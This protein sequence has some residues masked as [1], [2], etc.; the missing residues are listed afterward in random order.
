MK[1]YGIVFTLSLALISIEMIWTRILSAEFFYTFAFLVLSLAIL[2]L[3]T[4]ALTIRL[5]SGLNREKRIPLYT[6]FCFL[7]AI[8]GPIL[9]FR[10]GLDFSQLF[11]S[12]MIGLKLAGAS[13]LLSAPFFFG[14]M[15]LAIIF[16]SE[17]T[18][19]NKLYMADLFGAGTGVFTA[20]LLMNAFGT[21]MATWLITLLLLFVLFL[22]GRLPYKALAILGAAAILFTSGSAE[23]LLEK[24]REER[25]SVIYKHWDA[26]SKIKVYQYPGD[27]ARGINIDNIANTPVYKFDGNWDKPDSLLYEFGIPVD[28]LIKQFDSCTFLSLGSGG[29]ADVMQALQ[30]GANEVHAVEVNS[31]INRMMLQGHPQGYLAWGSDSAETIVTLDDYSG[32]VYHDPRV[33][34]ITEDARI[35]ARQNPAT[36]DVIYSLSSNTWSALASG[37][38]ALAENYLFTTEAFQ[39]Y[40][41]ALS[42]QGF[43]M[44]EHQFYVPR[45]V[46]EVMDA[47]EAEGLEKLHDHFAVYN[48]PQLR[49]KAILLSKRPLTDSLRYHA[50][51]DL[52]PENHDYIH[53]L[54]PAVDSLKHNDVYQ[55]VENSWQTHAD[56]VAFDISPNTDNRPFAAQMGLWKNLQKEKLEKI[57]PYE[58]FGFPLTKLLILIILGVVT[59]LI[60]PVNL[61]PFGIS[62]EKLRAPA[63]LYFFL[64]GAAFMMVE[65]ILIQKYTLFIGPSVYS[66]A[67]ILFTLLIAAGFGS[68]FSDRVENRIAFAGILICLIVDISLMRTVTQSLTGLTLPFRIG[69]S[70][71]FIAPLGFFMGMPFPKA[72]SRVGELVDWGFAVNGAASVIGSTA[73]MLVVITHGLN[74]GLLL[75]TALYGLAF[76]LFSGRSKWE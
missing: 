17:H 21:P 71:L 66:I 49:R 35:Y 58:F 47:L 43:M 60:L 40:W 72:V 15:V 53:L 76:L 16:R 67:A 31:H 57:L 10:L 70:M 6:L 5:F 62:K 11:H 19:M 36:F 42:D 45:L 55:I 56:S 41:N 8:L 24:Q 64:I 68:R 65:V 59:L 14:G 39:D 2:G 51:I 9:I 13:L 61:I 46:S 50:I 37:A 69:L 7:S 4:G 12:W 32:R 3:G 75:A 27:Q 30:F 18:R 63:W 44:M 74:V 1:K 28:Y 73:I 34:V 23:S 48:L 22:S 20:I 38:F 52:T 54:Y 25:A 26:M 33:R 29:G